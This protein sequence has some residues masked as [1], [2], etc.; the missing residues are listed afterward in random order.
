MNGNSK[1]IKSNRK[2]SDE[3]LRDAMEVI[4]RSSGEEDQ[5]QEE[6]GQSQKDA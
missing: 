1:L 4:V 6:R 2:G 5:E 3:Q